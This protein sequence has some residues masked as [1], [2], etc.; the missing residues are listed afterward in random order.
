PDSHRAATRRQTSQGAVRR[1]PTTCPPAGASGKPAATRRTSALPY[2][3]VARRLSAAD[4][5]RWPLGHSLALS[6]TPPAAPAESAGGVREPIENPLQG[7]TSS[8]P[9]T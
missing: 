7:A 5:H 9:A 2:R 3:L 4:H 8:Q 1:S 6:A